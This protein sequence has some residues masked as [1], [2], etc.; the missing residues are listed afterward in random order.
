MYFGVLRG[1]L[2]EFIWSWSGGWALS[3]WINESK[4]E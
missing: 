1:T 2:G 4:E 3:Q